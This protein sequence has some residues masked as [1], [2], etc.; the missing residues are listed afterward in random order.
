MFNFLKKKSSPKD[1]LH[2]LA[3]GKLIPLEQVADDVFSQKMMGDGF[4][5][6]PETGEI[7]APITGKIES[8]FPTKH[9]L[10]ISTSTGLE[11]MLHLG[12]DTVELNGAPFSLNVSEGQ[13]VTAGEPL[14]KMDLA[15]VTAAGKETTVIVVITN[16]DVV[17]ELTTVETRSV[18]AGE[19]VQEIS[20][21]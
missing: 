3:T 20:L 4:A 17:A 19:V 2:A 5:V 18:T 9:A 7:V 6:Q 12:L 16:M 14:V 15:A 11:L 13:M 8:I 10:T 1:E 21:K